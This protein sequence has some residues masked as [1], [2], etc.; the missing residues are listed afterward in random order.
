MPG[1]YAPLLAAASARYGV[2]VNL[3][4]AQ[5]GAE[6]SGNP[7]AVSDA[8]AQGL[9]QIMPSNFAAYGITNP[10]D[11]A[12]SIDAGAHMDA[13][14]FKSTGNW[15]AALSMYHGGT[16]RANWGP[17]TRAYTEKIMASAQPSDS[18]WASAM[19]AGAAQPQVPTELG[20]AAP[21]DAE[22]AAAM[23]A[24]ATAKPGVVASLGAGAGAGF[25]KTVLSGQKLLGEGLQ[26]IGATSAGNWLVGDANAGMQN[27]SSQN[28][29]FAASHPTWNDVGN[30]GGE[31]VATAPVLGAAGKLVAGGLSGAG[32]A[33][34]D[35]ALGNMLVAGGRL[36][37]GTV[38]GSGL[39]GALGKTAS[40]AVRGA[41]VGAG[42]NALTGGNPLSGAKWGAIGA[43]LAVG[44]MKLA[45]AIATPAAR[46]V[47]NTVAELSPQWA[48]HTAISRVGNALTLDNV[49]PSQVAQ[50]MREMGP[51][52]TP[53]DAV[54]SLTGGVNVRNMAEV[55]ANSPG[56]GAS[57]ANDVLRSR[58]E[59][60][61]QRVNDAI[62]T[63]TGA[64]GNVYADADA[65]MQQRSTAAKPLYD[66]AL[67][68]T[69]E[70][71]P[72]LMQFMTSPVF[73]AAMKDGAQ[74]ARIDA[75]KNGE[76]FD[77][78]QYAVQTAADGSPQAV[79]MT[80]A[81]A[82]KIGLDNM[83]EKSIDPATRRADA[84]GRALVGLRNEFVN[85][86]DSANPDYA[87]ARAAW[88]GPSSSLDALALGRKA[89]TSDAEVTSANVAGMTPSDK[90]FFL[91][92]VTRALQDK[93]NAAQDGADVTRKIFGNSLIRSRIKA[94][95]DDP[96]AFN[97]FEQ[98]MR[99]EAV[100]AA[101]KNA[102]L[103]GSPTARRMAG[104]TA[105]GVFAE[106]GI[107]ANLLTG[108]VGNAAV[109]VGRALTRAASTPGER[110]LA[111]QSGLLFQQNPDAFAAA[112]QRKPSAIRNFLTGAAA[113]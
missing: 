108:N 41:G 29:P 43:P 84:T 90:Q 74:I 23:S 94:A 104:Q 88:S 31:I 59:G 48:T 80:A 109:G 51:E 42:F 24:P 98:Q 7:L 44:G 5:M 3:L 66:K 34:G 83:I 71:T 10:S 70:P 4:T 65:L 87:A 112:F 2:P 68:Q 85:Y 78:A 11:P 27:L 81:N 79:S 97:A 64:Q 105:Q 96:E 1:Q 19:G 103:A 54:A 32:A 53:A 92:G 100:F 76:A 33:L 56:V 14:N 82:A 25:G 26:K 62:K 55:A 60:A 111:A 50:R 72:R 18:E 47:G 73:Q 102:I 86:L 93:I 45:G 17:K 46:I 15:G 99:N 107:G 113:P 101:N 30:L 58:A 6:S 12:Q 52:A 106:P 69:L 110:Q 95:F 57:Q 13:D 28:A 37:S 35:T 16:N 21:S 38:G 89:L 36:A 75:L 9:M 49:T 67:A 8:G 40:L 63:A 77:P 22:W 61:Q 91:S 20:A 39:P